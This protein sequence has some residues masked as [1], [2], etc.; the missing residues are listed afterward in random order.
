MRRVR[1]HNN[2]KAGAHYTKIRRPVVL[3]YA[4]GYRTLSDAR[5]GEAALKRL[6]RT[7]KFTHI[8]NASEKRA[9]IFSLS[10]VKNDMGKGDNSQRKEKK[11]PK[12]EKIRKPEPC[13]GFLFLV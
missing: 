10:I 5:R 3:K 6:T 13:S 11:K 2:S 9:T 12:K 7:Q 1:E 8:A 4:E